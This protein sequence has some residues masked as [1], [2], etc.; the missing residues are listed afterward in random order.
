VDVWKVTEQ[1]EYV[2]LFSKSEELKEPV[3]EAK[4]VELDNWNKNCV[5]QRVKDSGQTCVSSRW[6]ITEKRVSGCDKVRLKARL[7]C[8]GYEEDSSWLRTDSPTC[9]KES[10]RL[11][12]CATM[13]FDW[14]CKSLDVK[15]AFLQG[16]PIEREIYMRP[17]R[18]IEENGFIWKL[19]R[20]P[21]GL[22]DAPRSWFNRVKSELDKLKVESSIYDEALFFYKLDGKLHGIMALHVDDFMY[23]GSV[24][25]IKEVI[26]KLVAVFEVS[27]Q[28][29][30]N[31]KYVGLD[32]VQTSSCRD[33][34]RELSIWENIDIAIN[35]GY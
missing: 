19:C 26:N 9:T 6:V 13:S 25:F 20:C 1:P 21:Y 24:R 28:N 32:I 31:F 3:I 33:A 35:L 7:V 16:F 10:L 11:V 34:Y 27:V 30:T 17:P 15:S 4:Q 14:K 8:R 29:C 12:A 2:V 22:N 18:D 5:Y 23:G